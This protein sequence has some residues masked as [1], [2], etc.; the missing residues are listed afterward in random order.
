MWADRPKLPPLREK[1]WKSAVKIHPPEKNLQYFCE[2]TAPFQ[3]PDYAYTQG[4][5][6]FVLQ[7]LPLSY[8]PSVMNVIHYRNCLMFVLF[9][10][11]NALLA[12]IHPP[13]SA[14]QAIVSHSKQTP[15]AAHQI[16]NVCG[17]NPQIGDQLELK[18]LGLG[19]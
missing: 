18:W 11:I 5:R 4:V 19:L 3:N 10:S 7:F 1:T 9:V 8:L 17:F 2:T 16:Q 13:R 14:K 15:G 12:D 6:K